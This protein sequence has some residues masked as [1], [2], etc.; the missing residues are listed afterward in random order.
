MESEPNEQMQSG[1]GIRLVDGLWYD[2]RGEVNLY[3]EGQNPIR[4]WRI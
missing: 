4:V 1:N 3:V 2:R